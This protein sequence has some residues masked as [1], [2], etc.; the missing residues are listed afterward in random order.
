MRVARKCDPRM[1]ANC[2][3]EKRVSVTCRTG[4]DHRGKDKVVINEGTDIRDFHL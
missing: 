1:R 2:E 4:D 3:G